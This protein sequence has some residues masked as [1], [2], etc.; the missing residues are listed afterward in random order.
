MRT[1]RFAYGAPE[2]MLLCAAFTDLAHHYHLPMFGTAGVTDAVKMDGQA[3]AEIALNCF[4]ALGSGANLVHDVGMFAGAD[5]TSMAAMVFTDEVISMLQR[6]IQ[7]IDTSAESLALDI[8]ETVGPGGNFLSQK[9]TLKHHREM[10]TSNL[11]KRI[12]VDK[13]LEEPKQLNE[14]I[15]DKVY[16]ILEKHQPAPLEQGVLDQLDRMEKSWWK[17]ID[18]QRKR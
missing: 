1:T 15:R 17:E 16:E 3:A 4:L 12:S 6:V 2:T 5:S 18:N 11:F 9:H 14:R 13:W 7:P 10:W 8:V